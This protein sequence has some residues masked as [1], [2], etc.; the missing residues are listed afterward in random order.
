MI[1]LTIGTILNILTEVRQIVNE[2]IKSYFTEGWNYLDLTQVTMNAI[3]IG[4]MS[5]CVYDERLEFDVET[6]R[7]I[8][9]LSSFIMWVKCFYWMR[10]FEKFA[11]FITLIT[12]T[13]VDMST[14]MFMLMLCIF[15]FTN[16]IVIINNNSSGANDPIKEKYKDVYEDD[17]GNKINNWTYVTQFTDVAVFNAFISMWRTGL[18]EFDDA[19]YDKGAYTYLLWTFFMMATFIILVVFMNM[20]IAIMTNTY[21]KVQGEQEESMFYEQIQIIT[22][23]VWMLD[24]NSLFYNQKYIIRVAPDVAVKTEKNIL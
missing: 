8:S 23:F 16:F 15:A 22:D 2:G 14:F 13:I 17:L 9:A 19:H 10:L 12:Q 20:L 1:T 24:L 4:M 5:M 6:I 7:V 3:F 11:H 18:G 21:E